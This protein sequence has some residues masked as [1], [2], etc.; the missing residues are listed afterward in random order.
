M[1]AELDLKFGG[2][3]HCLGLVI[4][5]DGVFGGELAAGQCW[6]INPVGMGQDSTCSDWAEPSYRGGSEAP[7]WTHEFVHFSCRGSQMLENKGTVSITHRIKWGF[8]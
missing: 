1:R 8:E 5:G 6:A 3:N 4:A 7:G 2:F